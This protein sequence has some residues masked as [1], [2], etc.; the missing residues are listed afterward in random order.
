MKH[1]RLVSRLFLLILVVISVVGVASVYA[2]DAE[3]TH[4]TILAAIPDLTNFAAQAE[5][6]FVGEVEGSYAYIAVVVQGDL[7]IIYICDGYDAW[8]WIRAEVVDGEIHATHEEN[9]IQVDAVVT[10]EGVTGTVLLTTDDDGSE[11]TSHEFTTVPAIPGETGLARYADEFE[12]SGWIVTENGIRGIRKRL[13]CNSF[14]RQVE[15][16]REQMNM[17]SDFGVKNQIAGQIID[18]N[19]ESATAGC[20]HY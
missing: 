15:Y 6:T 13:T 11:A 7:A 2:Q 17:N 16:L 5:Q 12:V 4:E 14:Q 3:V 10:A 1:S 19:T 18:V 20:G 9:G 8:G